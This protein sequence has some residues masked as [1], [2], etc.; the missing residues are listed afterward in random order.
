MLLTVHLR[1]ATSER[2]RSLARPISDI[3]TDDLCQDDELDDADDTGKR[4]LICDEFGR[5]YE[6]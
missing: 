4:R 3:G 5:N 1:A 6:A 2:A